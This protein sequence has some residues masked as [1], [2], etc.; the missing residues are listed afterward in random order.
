MTE[1]KRIAIIPAYN[2][3]NSIVKQC[4]EIREKGRGMTFSLSMT[5][6]KMQHMRNA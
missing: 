3:E 6:R 2:E 4:D 5:A 1:H